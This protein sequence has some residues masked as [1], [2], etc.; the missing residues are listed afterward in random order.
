[1]K[2]HKT[3]A[4][5]KIKLVDLELSHLKT[6]IKRIDKKAIEG[7]TVRMGGGSTAEDMYYDEDVYYGE[8]VRKE[9][10]YYHYI[11]ELN[12]REL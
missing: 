6:I 7:L 8:E 5:K 11:A 2:Y 3:K 12:R 9:L 4:G 10:N 1:M